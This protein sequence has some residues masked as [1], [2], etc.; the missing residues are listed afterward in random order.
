MERFLNKQLRNKL[1]ASAIGSIWHSHAHTFEFGKKPY[2]PDHVASFVINGLSHLDE[3]W[4]A[5]LR[6]FQ[7]GVQITGVFCHQYPQV[8][9]DMG[10]QPE[11]VEL[12]DLLVVRRHYSQGKIKKEVATL[13]QSKMSHDSTKKVTEKDGQHFLYNNWPEFRF[14]QKGY[15]KHKRDIGLCKEQAKYNLIFD[16]MLYPE[17]NTEWPDSCFW[18]VADHTQIHMESDESFAALLDGMVAFER[19]REFFSETN[20][21]CEWTKTILELLNV[22]FHKRL[23]TMLYKSPKRGTSHNMFLMTT[24]GQPLGATGFAS[25]GND[26]HQSVEFSEED[27]P[28]GISTIIIE[29]F[30]LEDEK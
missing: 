19:G 11:T 12:A 16:K 22:T 26:G 8:E 3:L 30:D 17:D 9:F 4:S 13:F 1:K 5:Q 6:K 21:A 14:T 25:S 24:A 15:A 20:P 27:S 28:P 18:S 10:G 23:K 29:T 2:E 7:L